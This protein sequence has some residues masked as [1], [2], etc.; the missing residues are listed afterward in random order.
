MIP[1]RDTIRSQT[2][3]FVNYALIGLCAW[4]FYL[5]LSNG[6]PDAFITEHALVPARFVKLVANRGL[7]LH[8]LSPFLSS[9]FM[10]GGFMHF[11]GNMLFLWIFGDNVEDRM[12]HVGYLLFYLAGGLAAGATHVFV[13]PASVIPTV[14]ASGAIA[15]VMGAYMVL[16]PGSRIESALIFFIFVRI[17]SVP[18]VLW[19]G[20]WFV[21]QVLSGSSD[22]RHADQGGVAFFAHIGGFVFGA[23]IGLLFK[24]RGQPQ[25]RMV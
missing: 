13:N 6:D 8:V 3:P 21:F 17:I 24:V 11:A 7:N 5:E 2:V 18:A 16:Y 12:G 9:M 23:A 19:L 14:G 20:L 10:H 4:V 15:A 25:R 22:P 1:I